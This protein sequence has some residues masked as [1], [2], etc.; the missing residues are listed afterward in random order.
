MEP[1]QQCA[2]MAQRKR[3]NNAPRSCRGPLGAGRRGKSSAATV[4]SA[5]R[6]RLLPHSE[7]LI[8]QQQREAH[9]V[10]AN[11]HSD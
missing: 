1:A 8:A 10:H 6:R 2:S 11:G 4:S 7:R 9:A 5:L 3:K